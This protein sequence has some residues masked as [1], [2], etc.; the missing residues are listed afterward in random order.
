MDSSPASN[1]LPE[2]FDTPRRNLSS[3]IHNHSQGMQR[4]WKFW[5]IIF[6]LALSSLATALEATAIGAALPTIIHDLKGE[7]DQFIWVG[8]GYGL[9]ATALVPLCGGLTPIFGRQRVM[10]SAILLFALGSTTCG[11][12]LSLNMLVAGRVVQGLGAGAISSTM[13]VI[14]SDLV[15][16]RERGTFTG[17][18]ALAW[19]IGA[20]VGRVAGGSLAEIGKWRWIFYLNLPICAMN[21]TLVLLFLRLKTTPANLKEK[22]GQIDIIGNILITASTTSLVIGLTWGGIQYPWSS[23]H[24]LSPLVIGFVGLGIFLIYEVYICKPPVSPIML[25]MNWTCASGYIQSFVATVL[26]MTLG[27]WLPVFFAACKEKSPAEASI[28]LFGLSFSNSLVALLTG[29]AVKKT[30]KYMTLIFIGWICAI[31]GAGL[32]TTLNENITIAKSIGFQA[33]IAGGVGTIYVTTLFPILASV[34]ITQT[35]PAMALSVFSRNFGTIWGAAVGGAI[36]QN[37]LKRKLPASFLEQFPQGAE[38]AFATITVI[39][40]LEQPFRDEVRKAFAESFSVVWWVTL[41]LA[42]AGSLCTIGMEQLPL[43]A[44][45]DKDWGTEDAADVPVP[46]PPDPEIGRPTWHVSIVLFNRD[47][48]QKCC[49]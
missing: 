48:E 4:D 37:E 10:L 11:A 2:P 9:G 36:L 6:S 16:L 14:V 33:V 24:V 1:P 29:V 7:G 35:A 5:C 15:T 40:T 42:I 39:P 19:A 8:S 22:L 26:I 13:Q 23:A 41:A 25:R 46:S 32:L 49:K 21:A 30:G 43:H 38:I 20:G 12:A 47:E 45:V 17:L 27:Y 28:D 31:V 18:M 34:P 44:E 3:G